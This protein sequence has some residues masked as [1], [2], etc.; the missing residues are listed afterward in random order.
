M[1][2][3]PPP[4]HHHGVFWFGHCYLKKKT[5]CLIFV[6]PKHALKIH[7]RYY[8]QIYRWY[9][10]IY[11]GITL[12]LFNFCFSL[13]YTSPSLS[14]PHARSEELFGNKPLVL[15]NFFNARRFFLIQRHRITVLCLLPRQI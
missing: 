15:T 9:S 3:P 7:R 4:H 8:L 2:A 1:V 14:L 10:Q 12:I 11:A 13:I 5:Y 6:S